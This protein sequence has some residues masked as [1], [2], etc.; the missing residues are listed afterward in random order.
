[1]PAAWGFRTTGFSS[2]HPGGCNFVMADGSVHF[3]KKNISSN[4]LRALT[5]RAVGDLVGS[6]F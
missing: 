4:T 2:F 6:D 5:T 1:M 3:I